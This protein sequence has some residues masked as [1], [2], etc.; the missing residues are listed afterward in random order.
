MML[1][2]TPRRA[3]VG[4]KRRLG[5]QQ[6]L[7]WAFG[8]EHARLDLDVVDPENTRSAAVSSE[9]V[10]WQ[11]F[12]LGA[13]VDQGGPAWGGSLPHHD[14]EVI[15]AFVANLRDAEGGR[16]MGV[17]IAELAR[18]GI[19]PDWMP[20]AKVRCVPQDWRQ[21]KHGP[22]ARTEVIDTITHKHR[23]RTIKRD[24]TWCPVT[25]TPTA[26]QINRA[27]REY[28]AWWGALLSLAADL[29]GCGMLSRIEVTDAMPPMT[30][31]RKEG[32]GGA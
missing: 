6:A 8:K 7:E 10:I 23:G 18:A 19:T 4:T 17:R 13:T 1:R 5:I 24:V 12:L 29:G 21:T 32:K 27:R 28:L 3:G 25:Y 11:R 14:A 2:E 9:Y 26:Q 22:F 30:P 16:S 31:W 15:A 20:G